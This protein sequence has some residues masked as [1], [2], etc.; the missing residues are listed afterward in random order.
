MIYI[1]CPKKFSF[2]IIKIHCG[3]KRPPGQCCGTQMKSCKYLSIYLVG[4]E[5]CVFKISTKC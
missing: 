5:K 3:P 2:L 1:L 4:L